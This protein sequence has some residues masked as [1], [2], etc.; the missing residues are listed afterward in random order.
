VPATPAV[1]RRRRLVASLAALLLIALAIVVTVVLSGAGAA[2]PPAIGAASVVPADALVYVHVSTDQGRAP[3]TQTVALDRRL[4]GFYSLT[5]SVV[6][7][8]DAILGGGATLNY[9]R[10]VRPWIG[11]EAA[12]ALLDT[13]SSSAGSLIVLDVRDRGRAQALLRRTG[14]TA[15][16]SYRGIAIE[17]YS[18]GTQLAFVRHYLVLGQDASVRS[19]IDVATKSAPSLAGNPGYDE[20]ATG[21]PDD[22]V[23]D[24]YVS[25]A[26]V[27]RVLANATG[28]LGALGALLSQPATTA[29]TISVSPA[30]GGVRVRVHGAL[31]AGLLKLTGRPQQ[32]KPKLPDVLPTGSMVL[33]DAARLDTAVPRILDALGSLGIADRVQPLIGHLGSALSAQSVHLGNVLELLHGEAAVALIPG[34]AGAPA[35]AIIARVTNQAQARQTL[36]NLEVPL[37]QLFPA[38]GSG[39]G[40]EAEWNDEQVAGVTVHELGVTPGLQLDY[41][42]FDGLAVVSTSPDAIGAIARHAHPLSADAGYRTAVGDQAKRV[43]SLVSIDF[44]Q[45]L[46]LAEQTGL[47]HGASVGAI[48]PDLARIHA[49]GLT[50]AAGE[51]DTTAELFLQIS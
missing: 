41:A 28:P 35:P 29:T 13:T 44:S 30:S 1:H 11:K 12:L 32:F 8:L 17:G 34:A 5:T 4:P 6:D 49:V 31:S 27:R 33:V 51:N 20:A 48:G 7:R 43:T 19:A 21:E 15:A 23:L 24:A 37:Q 47:T 42:V 22:R 38:P 26:G 50:S 45:L 39:P 25:A 16:G 10:D 40:Q 9:A 36:A 2:A 18:T 3:V 46:S 14:A